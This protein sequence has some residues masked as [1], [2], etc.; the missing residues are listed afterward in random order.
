MKTLKPEILAYV[1]KTY[2]VEP[3]CPFPSSPDSPVLRHE[4]NRK[5]FAI[6][7][8]VRR[9]RLGLTGEEPVEVMNCK[10]SPLLAGVL[11][12][13]AGI[14]PAY[15]MNRENWITVLLDGTVPPEDIFPLLDLS[16][17]LTADKKAR[18]GR[19]NWLV[20]ANPKYYDV[21]EALRRAE[22]ETILWKQSSKVKPG[23]I[24]YLY[25]AAPI[26]GIQYQFRAVEVDIPFHHRGG[27]IRIDRMM[28]LRLL[29]TYEPPVR[30]DVLK[31]HGVT[32]V[33]GPRYMPASLMEEIDGPGK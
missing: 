5:W 1:K 11:R 21:A 4:D 10:T 16:F 8:T 30:L 17:E 27:A 33:R 25:M 18:K 29:K 31:E 9:S 2:G 22:D 12:Q 20:P 32:T 23:D 24:I 7:M 28:R 14:L 19:V 3:D 26:S 13:Q 15:H 6:F